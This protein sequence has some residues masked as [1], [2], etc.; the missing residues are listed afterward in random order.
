[1]DTPGQSKEKRDS[2]K[3]RVSQRRYRERQKEAFNGIEEVRARNCQRYYVRMAHRKAT[4]QYE[5]FKAKKAKEAMRRYHAMSEE[6]HNEVKCKNL[7]LQKA[8]RNRMI[9]EGTYEEYRRR[10]NA[11]RQQQMAEKKRAM[12]IEEW[13]AL[14]RAR[15]V[16]RAESK[17]RK[18]CN[19]L[20]EHLARLFPLRWLYWTGQSRSL[21]RRRRRRTRCKPFVRTR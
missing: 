12:G 4:G 17:R 18:R 3:N 19:W 20:D 15:Y 6:Q 5:A 11:R 8:W 21:R 2:Q 13:K 1:M 16:K 9:Q 14:Q 7:I 10:L